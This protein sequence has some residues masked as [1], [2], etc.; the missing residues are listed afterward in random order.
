MKRNFDLI[1][2][3][4]FLFEEKAGSSKLENPAIEGFNSDEIAYHCRLLYDAGFLRCE[5]VKSST[6]DRIIHAIP[7]ELTWDG[8]EF[9][10]KIRCE[11]TWSK[12]KSYAKERSL[13]LSFD[14]VSEIAKKFI[15]EVLKIPNTS[16]NRD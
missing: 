16:F 14:I 1:R 7:F 15:T 5:C 4:L 6:S 12:I 3:L 8:H 13:A 2:N 10:E 11:S 9:L